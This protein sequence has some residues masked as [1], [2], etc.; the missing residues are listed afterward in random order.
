MKM[1][2]HR[3]ELLQIDMDEENMAIPETEYP[4]RVNVEIPKIKKLLDLCE[5]VSIDTII[6]NA[7]KEKEEVSIINDSFS[8]TVL[9]SLN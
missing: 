6:F 9:S 5:K 1:G 3:F 4:I 8:S 7:D 2:V